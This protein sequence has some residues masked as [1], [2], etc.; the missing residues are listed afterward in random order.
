M[1]ITYTDSA[2]HGECAECRKRFTRRAI[3]AADD[4]KLCRGCYLKRK[5]KVPPSI[6]E[7]E[8]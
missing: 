8:E 7:S 2:R 4:G 6:K 1:I 5:R 3:D